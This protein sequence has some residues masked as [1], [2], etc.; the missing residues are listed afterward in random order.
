MRE[1][2][3]SIIRPFVSWYSEGVYIIDKSRKASVNVVRFIDCDDADGRTW[4]TNVFTASE[5][6]NR[7]IATRLIEVAVDYC[8][9]QQIE[10]LYLFCN[11]EHIPFYEKRG[12][13]DIHSI[14]TDKYGNA[15]YTMMRKI[16]AFSAGERLAM[17]CRGE[18]R[19]K[20]KNENEDSDNNTK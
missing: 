17:R 4:L 13:V 20:N 12:F 10:A 16:P 1:R 3:F 18:N 2:G 14:R 5:Y 15:E 7:G 6:R 9:K 19:R 11:R 8:R